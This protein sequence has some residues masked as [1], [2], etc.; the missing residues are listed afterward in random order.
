MCFFSVSVRLTLCQ[1]SAELPCL[2][3]WSGGSSHVKDMQLISAARGVMSLWSRRPTT[4]GLTTRSAMLTRSRWRTSSATSPTP[5]RLYH[6]GKKKKDK[7]LSWKGGSYFT[8]TTRSWG[9]KV[10]L[11]F[12]CFF[13]RSPFSPRQTFPR[14]KELLKLS[15]HSCSHLHTGQLIDISPLVK[16]NLFVHW[17]DYVGGIWNFRKLGR[18]LILD[19]QELTSVL[20]SSSNQLRVVASVWVIISVAQR[21]ASHMN[22]LLIPYLEHWACF[23]QTLVVHWSGFASGSEQCPSSCLLSWL[24][25]HRMLPLCQ[26]TSQQHFSSTAAYP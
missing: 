21:T 19:R 2:S 24:P 20:Q 12:F 9:L 17:R 5:T 11:S 13:S 1:G 7:T 26:M 25:S 18:T 14:T 4:A 6:K 8:N 10:R 15:P 3:G 23:V 16:C 22:T